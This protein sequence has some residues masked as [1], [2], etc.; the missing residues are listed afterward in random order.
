MQEFLVQAMTSMGGMPDKEIRKLVS[1]FG[2]DR[3]VA[4]LA[5]TMADSP[6]SE[7]LSDQQVQELCAAMVARATAGGSHAARR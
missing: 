3:A 5:D 2:R 7:I 4:M 6:L 1:E